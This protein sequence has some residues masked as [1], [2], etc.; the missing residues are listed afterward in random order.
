MP[1]NILSVLYLAPTVYHFLSTNVGKVFL[2]HTPTL[3]AKYVPYLQ[4]C[5]GKW[6]K[7]FV[8]TALRF[9]AMSGQF[10]FDWKD[11][12]RLPKLYKRCSG[13]YH[14]LQCVLNTAFLCAD[15]F[16]VCGIRLRNTERRTEIWDTRETS[17]VPQGSQ[18][19]NEVT[20]LLS[21]AWNLDDSRR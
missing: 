10:L 19:S 2:R 21:P 5:K 17:D 1:L 20:I 3:R 11:G 12:Y 4:V 16:E 6:I 8:V 7:T 15:T 14:S 18:W 13:T 9:F